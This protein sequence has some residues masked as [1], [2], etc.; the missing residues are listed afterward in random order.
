[1]NFE[2]QVGFGLVLSR[3]VPP[4]TVYTAGVEQRGW[5]K[6]WFLRLIALGWEEKKD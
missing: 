3:Q 2:V 5:I 6:E 1:M 4:N